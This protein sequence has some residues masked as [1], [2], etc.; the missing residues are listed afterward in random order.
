ML[1]DYLRVSFTTDSGL[2]LPAPAC[3]TSFPNGFKTGSTVTCTTA[4]TASGFDLVVSTLADSQFIYRFDVAGVVNAPSAK[5]VNDITCKTCVDADCTDIKDAANVAALHFTAAAAVAGT[6]SVSSSSAINGVKDATLSFQVRAVQPFVSHGCVTATLP[7][8]NQNYLALGAAA[9]GLITN[10]CCGGTFTVAASSKDSGGTSTVQPLSPHQAPLFQA[11]W[12]NDLLR[13]CL[14]NPTDL[15]AGTTIVLEITPITNPPSL[16]PISGFQAAITDEN[17]NAVES[18]T[19]TYE[20]STTMPGSFHAGPGVPG[21]ADSAGVTGVTVDGD[22]YMVGEAGQ[23]YD[24]TLYTAGA[25]PMGAKLFLTIPRAWTLDCNTAS[26]LPQVKCAQGCAFANSATLC[27][28]V[29]NQLQFLQGWPTTASYTHA[30]GPIKFYL[31]GMTN[32]TTT[33]EQY[34]GVTTYHQDGSQYLIDRLL[35][36]DKMLKLQ[37]STGIVTVTDIMPTEGMIYSSAGAYNFTM[38]FQHPILDTYALEITVPKTLGVLQK[39][40]C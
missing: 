29:L 8:V 13:V 34:F 2:K 37:F 40:G 38:S 26:S 10:A 6:L 22:K 1:S 25:M 33:T 39:A 18:T 32:P 21:A 27:D 4:T 31:S 17:A 3:T 28:T 16:K 19:G 15:P 9:E 12:D 11:K 24:F 35:D 20:L 14:Y 7:K 5:F 23:R 30:P 36:T